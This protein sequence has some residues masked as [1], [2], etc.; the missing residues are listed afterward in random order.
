[1]KN[2]KI[3]FWN[4]VIASIILSTSLLLGG[5]QTFA[6]SVFASASGIFI[7][8][9]LIRSQIN[10]SKRDAY[11]IL[12]PIAI[13]CLVLSTPIYFVF[14]VNILWIVFGLI[15]SLGGA[16]GIYLLNRPVENQTASIQ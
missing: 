9:N 7:Y 8:H 11:K 3:A 10:R 13:V 1:M 6:V 15:F 5:W 4:F 16:L 2:K 12:T 14:P